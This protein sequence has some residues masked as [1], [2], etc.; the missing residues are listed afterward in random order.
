[1]SRIILVLVTLAAGFVLWL[2][3]HRTPLPQ[4]DMHN[5]PQSVASVSPVASVLPESIRQAHQM[6]PTGSQTDQSAPSASP[7]E[8]SEPTDWPKLATSLES[9]KASDPGAY[10]KAIDWL[11]ETLVTDTNEHNLSRASGALFNMN[12]PHLNERVIKVIMTERDNLSSE[13][14]TRLLA[15]IIYKG[16]PQ[17][18]V[19]KQVIKVAESSEHEKVRHLATHWAELKGQTK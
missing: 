6:S 15:L 1:M 12:D 5:T 8:G 3:Q 7:F 18:D 9:R 19:F 14:Y 4:A 11:L 10:G 16:D 13:S 2:T 17:S